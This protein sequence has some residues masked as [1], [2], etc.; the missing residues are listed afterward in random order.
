MSSASATSGTT[1]TSSLSLRS[2]AASLRLQILCS[3]L[4]EVEEPVSE[5]LPVKLV[6][7]LQKSA[8]THIKAGTT[9]NAGSGSPPVTVVAG[10]K[11]LPVKAVQG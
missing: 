1:T 2:C 10:S 9:K 3:K 6:V 4:T 8:G 11:L 5:K 7:V